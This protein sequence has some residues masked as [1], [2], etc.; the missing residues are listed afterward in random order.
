MYYFFPY[1]FVLFMS[2][3]FAWFLVE[4]ISVG[5]SQLHCYFYAFE[6]NSMATGKSARILDQI[7]HQDFEIL[8]DQQ[9]NVIE[10]QQFHFTGYEKLIHA[11]HRSIDNAL[12]LSKSPIQ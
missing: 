12:L 4:P 2:S 11:F 7:L 6:E 3:G 5:R 8:E 10:L 9:R 1:S